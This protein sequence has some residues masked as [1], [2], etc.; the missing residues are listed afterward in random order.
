MLTRPEASSDVVQPTWR[1]SGFE[2]LGFTRIKQLI[3]WVRVHICGKRCSGFFYSARPWLCLSLVPPFFPPLFVRHVR[4]PSHDHNLALRSVVLA[5]AKDPSTLAFFPW[6]QNTTHTPHVSHILA[7]KIISSPFLY[8]VSVRGLPAGCRRPPFLLPWGQTEGDST[9][10]FSFDFLAILSCHSNF[11]KPFTK[12]TQCFC[13]IFRTLANVGVSVIVLETAIKE[14]GRGAVA[15][16]AQHE[17]S[18][19]RPRR[20]IHNSWSLM[21]CSR[22]TPK[23]PSYKLVEEIKLFCMARL[24]K[25]GVLFAGKQK[26]GAERLFFSSAC[27]SPRNASLL[28]PPLLSAGGRL[29]YRRVSPFPGG[30]PG[31]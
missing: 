12:E 5:H 13:M 28:C 20:R 27:M 7:G 31:R 22:L 16:Y 30:I 25:D 11:S 2:R 9:I 24:G 23:K 10:C 14:E 29:L 8:F 3:F 21:R 4:K 17:G 6:A 1:R 18:R 15:R 19:G 26:R